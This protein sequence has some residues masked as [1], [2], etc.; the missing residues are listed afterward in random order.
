MTEGSMTVNNLVAS[1]T[2]KE[3]GVKDKPGSSCSLHSGF[4]LPCV[5]HTMCKMCTQTV[6]FSSV[7]IV[8][9]VYIQTVFSWPTKQLSGV[10]YGPLGR[11]PVEAL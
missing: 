2:M 7:L 10:R 9:M 11:R 3:G 4:R 8:G 1:I 6:F 5:K